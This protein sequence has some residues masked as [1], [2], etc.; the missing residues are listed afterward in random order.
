MRSEQATGA[1]GT[2]RRTGWCALLLAAGLGAAPAHALDYGRSPNPLFELGSDR[3]GQSPAHALSFSVFRGELETY[4][5]V[6]TYPDGFRFRGFQALGPPGAQVGAVTLDLNGDGTADLMVPLRSMTSGL[7]YADVIPDGRFSSGLEPV[8]RHADVATFT[9][10]MPFGGDA[11]ADTLVTPF[12]ARVAIALFPGLIVSPRRAG[13]YA[14]TAELL[15]VDPDTDGADDGAGAPPVGLAFELPLLITA[16]PV[17]PFADLCIDKADIKDDGFTVHGRYALGSGSGGP[18]FPADAVTVTLGGFQQTIPGSA[19]SV[20]GHGLQ[21]HGREP[22]I[23]R[24]VIGRDGRFQL[25]AR[26]VDLNGL[27]R[28]RAPFSLQ[29]GDDRGETDLSFDRNG[30]LRTPRVRCGP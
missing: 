17:I 15:S 11:N 4:R 26:D 9:L 21:F 23:K 18:S 7:A 28:T 3:A 30:H 5:A 22:G 13:T 29:V 16:P 8:L 19:F 27:D 14:I 20:L 6:V 10:R 1:P 25:D 2:R 12:D 24:L